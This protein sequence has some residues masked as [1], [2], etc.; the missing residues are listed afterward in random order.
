MDNQKSSEPKQSNPTKKWRSPSGIPPCQSAKIRKKCPK[1]LSVMFSLL[2]FLTLTLT[3]LFSAL[4]TLLLIRTGI[5]VRQNRG[6][7]FF[8]IALV[9]I[10]VGTIISNYAGRH[11]LT[12]IIAMSN[13][14][15][16][17]ARGNFDVSLDENIR[18]KE[19][20]EMA[21]NFNLMAKELAGT[22]ILRT[23]FVENVSHEF[24]TPLSAIE[25]YATLLQKKDISA[26]KRQDY[27]KK[28]LYNTRRLSTLTSNI[29]LLSRLENQEIGIKKESFCLDEQLREILL[30][31]EESW[32][33]K[34]LELE[35]DL[36]AVDY[37]G[38]KDLLA[39]V[40]QNILSNAI[41]FAPENGIIHI[42]LRREN[43]SLITSITDNGI[44][45]SEDVMRRVFE[46]FYQG[47]FS[48]SSQGNGLGL[49][50]AKRIIDLHGR[51]I[52][53][54]SKEGKGTTFTVTLPL[55]L[56]TKGYDT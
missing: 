31:L 41:K 48:R 11:P 30:L 37:Y 29:L 53:V 40:W 16:E 9:S 38:N 24:K 20:R 26:E 4:L 43:G 27:T 45:M 25:G 36:D 54:S 1:R 17:V 35:I 12:A 44:G 49:A 13:A 19:L 23:D 39:H 42:L 5:L 18:I 6:I 34:Q 47:D 3:I 2:T 33:E 10:L 55:T 7:V 46:K 51:D 28:I 14:T 22:E 15:Q 21:H 52:A 56:H 8:V 50:L 32:T